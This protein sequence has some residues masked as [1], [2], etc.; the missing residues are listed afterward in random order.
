MS[1]YKYDPSYGPGMSEQITLHFTIHDQMYK[2]TLKRQS[3]EKTVEKIDADIEKGMSYNDICKKYAD[4]ISASV[5]PSDESI[6]SSSNM[7]KNEKREYIAKLI[8]ANPHMNLGEISREASKGGL[9]TY[10]NSRYL[11][12]QIIESRQ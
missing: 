1:D 7:T 12:Q 6:A 4:K 8:E 9:L 2:L 10:A 3:F 11:A 5:A